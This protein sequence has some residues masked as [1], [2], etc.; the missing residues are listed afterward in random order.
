MYHDLKLLAGK[1]DVKQDEKGLFIDGELNLNL[2]YVPDA[3]EQMKDNLLDGMSV[4]FNILPKGARWEES[5]DDGP[6]IRYITKAE[7]W[8]V[9]IVPFGMNPKAKITNVKD[10]L[11]MSSARD[12][13][14]MFRDMGYSQSKSVAMASSVWTALQSDSADRLKQSESVINEINQAFAIFKT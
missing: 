11:D 8:E 4:G 13:E 9:S 14:R 7:L 1:A 3:Y 2:S 6:M 12:F 5:D 10:A